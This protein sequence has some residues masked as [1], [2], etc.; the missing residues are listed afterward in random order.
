LDDVESERIDGHYDALEADLRTDVREPDAAAFRRR[1][2]LRY[3]GQSFELTV[4][5]G[6]RLDPELIEER[7]HET[8]AA[9]YGY[10]MDE[11]VHLVNLR[12]SATTERSAPAVAREASG[13]A[14]TGV[15]ETRFDD[16]AIHETSVYDRTGFA[17][18]RMLNG[19]VVI[20][21]TES[22]IV[23]PPKWDASVRRDGGLLLAE[24]DR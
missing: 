8:H 3:V 5:V 4:D 9:T 17:S 14:Q 18:G 10:R 19:P 22:T 24:A 7:F 1:A 2:D 6:D 23:I 11:P 21:P 15:R 12:V 13:D 20:E 16:G